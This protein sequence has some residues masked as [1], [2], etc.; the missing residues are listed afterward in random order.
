MLTIMLAYWPI[1]SIILILMLFG[2]FFF[3]PGWAGLTAGIVFSLS[4]AMTILSVVQKQKK[5]YREELMNGIKLARNGFFEILGIVIGMA[6][7]G[8]LGQYLAQ[9]L[10]QAIS[11]DLI[12]F[13][14]SIAASLLV[15]IGVGALMHHTWG[16]LDVGSTGRDI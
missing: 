12:K 13:A 11:N 4:L 8:L 7:A 5:M 6:L 14:V 9:A 16:R 10:T 1:L 2:V 3:M 15:G